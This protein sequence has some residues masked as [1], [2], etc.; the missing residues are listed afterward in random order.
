MPFLLFL[1]SAFCSTSG[2]LAEDWNAG[3]SGELL[4]TYRSGLRVILREARVRSGAVSLVMALLG[5]SV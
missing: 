4:G 3:I 1:L 5:C 2:A